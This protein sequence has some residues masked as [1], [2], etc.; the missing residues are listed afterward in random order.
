LVTACI[1]ASCV[2]PGA[3]LPSTCTVCQ[4]AHCIASCFVLPLVLQEEE[5]EKYAS[6]FSK[7]VDEGIEPDAIEDMYKEVSERTSE[8]EAESE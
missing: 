7:Y 8:S 3:V 5:P 2:S 4:V 6:H 1:P